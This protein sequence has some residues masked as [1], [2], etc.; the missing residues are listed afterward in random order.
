MINSVASKHIHHQIT[1]ACLNQRDRPTRLAGKTLGS[2]PH[3]AMVKFQ[4][5]YVSFPLC[6]KA[7]KVQ[8]PHTNKNI[9]K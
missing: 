3:Q 4:L 7:Q 1:S 9:N 2:L 8:T 6:P 5:S